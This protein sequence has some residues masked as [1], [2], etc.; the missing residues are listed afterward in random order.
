M[1]S[2]NEIHIATLRGEARSVPDKKVQLWGLCE[3]N[4]VLKMVET[5]KGG[6]VHTFI[7][8]KGCVVLEDGTRL[9]SG[10]QYGTPDPTYI[11]VGGMC[12]MRGTLSGVR[13]SFTQTMFTIE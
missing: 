8:E 9:E 7:V 13:Q 1:S 2:T 11:Y 12:G 3:G 6:E 4:V 5:R 10:A